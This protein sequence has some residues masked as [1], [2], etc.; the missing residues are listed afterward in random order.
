MHIA[1]RTYLLPIGCALKKH[2]R[3]ETYIGL[4]RVIDLRVF[5]VIISSKIGRRRLVWS[6]ITILILLP[7][8][9]LYTYIGTPT[10]FILF[11]NIHNCIIIHEII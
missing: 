2:L 4:R 3:A 8:L 5:S 9:V 11:D 10:T 6:N 7:E 1:H